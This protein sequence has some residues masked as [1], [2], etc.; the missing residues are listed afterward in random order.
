M[1]DWKKRRSE[2]GTRTGMERGRGD[3]ERSK[4]RKEVK[5]ERGRETGGKERRRGGKEKSRQEE[6]QRS[7]KLCDLSDC[8]PRLRG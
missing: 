2:R 7:P 5:R 4:E 8:P 1:Q 3:K 6:G